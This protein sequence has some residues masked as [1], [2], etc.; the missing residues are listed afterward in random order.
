M[1]YASYDHQ[2]GMFE[3]KMIKTFKRKEEEI[4]GGYR[5]LHNEELHNEFVT[6]YF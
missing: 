4:I 2:L 5:K 3:T 6:K 1:I